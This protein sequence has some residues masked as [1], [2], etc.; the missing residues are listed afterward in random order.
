MDA[1]ATNAWYVRHGR[2][3]A[4][5]RWRVSCFH[6]PGHGDGEIVDA[7]ADTGGAL[8]LWTADVD[9][10]GRLR[11]EVNPAAVPRSPATWFVLLD[12]RRGDPAA[13]ALVAFA[14]DDLPDGV[15]VDNATFMAM[16]VRSDQQVA[17]VQWEPDTAVAR[18][19]FVQPD[20]R[21]R[22]LATKMVYAASAYHQAQGWPGA[23]HSDGRRT[24]LGEE[25]TA[26]LRHPDRIAP[27]KERA[28]PMDPS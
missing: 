14:T 8:R 16:A 19:V 23:L 27:W 5:V 24:E 26:G 28:E 22:Q 11:L 10:D 4:H 9:G 2:A 15:V 18:Q 21:R 7:D 12:Q 20:W 13:M 1:A 17:A 6:G 25:F 3:D